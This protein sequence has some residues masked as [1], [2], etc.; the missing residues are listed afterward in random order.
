MQQGEE[1]RTSSCMM[2][3]TLTGKGSNKP[4][5][6]FLILSQLHQEKAAQS[7]V[8]GGVAEIKADAQKWKVLRLLEIG[9]REI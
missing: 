7:K 2:P 1:L 6:F 5:K 9:G 3:H 8:E 4:L